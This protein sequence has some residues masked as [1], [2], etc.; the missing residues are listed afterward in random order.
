MYS[1]LLRWLSLMSLIITVTTSSFSTRSESW[2]PPLHEPLQ[3]QRTFDLSQGEYQAGHRGIDLQSRPGT[4]IRSPVA[5]T[6]KFVGTVAQ[7][8][9]LTIEVNAHTLLS[10]EPMTSDL[11]AG[12]RVARGQPIGQVSAGGHC[13]NRCLHIGVRIHGEYVNPLRFFWAKPVLLPW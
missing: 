3:V 7:K 5:G 9:V 10:F 8:P 1:L 11:R 13:E 4:M 12:D 2:L 6:V